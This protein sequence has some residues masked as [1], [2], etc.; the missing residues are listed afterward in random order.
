MKIDILPVGE[1]LAG[2]V[3]KYDSP[4]FPVPGVI[5]SGKAEQTLDMSALSGD[6]LEKR[7]R[8]FMSCALELAKI[9]ADLGDVPV[10]CII[11]RG[12]A[13]VGYGI[14]ERERLKNAVR[15]AEVTAIDMACR[16]LGGWR[17]TGCELFVTLEPCIMCSGAIMNARIPRIIYAAPDTAGNGFMSYVAAFPYTPQTVPDVLGEESA[18]IIKEFFIKKR[19]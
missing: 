14:N 1:T 15:H 2:T 11:V 7:D 3:R 19:G 9:S 12:N 16:I 8:H 5:R 18:G 10:G 13:I 4:D 6:I 17:L